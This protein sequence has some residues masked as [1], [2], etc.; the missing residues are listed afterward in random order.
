MTSSRSARAYI[1]SNLIKLFPN[2]IKTEILS[3]SKLS[4]ELGLKTDATITFSDKEVAFSRASLFKAI[5]NAFK[6]SEQEYSVE[7]I[8]NNI[9]TLRNY[10]AESPM[11][12]LTKGSLQLINRNFWP[13]VD[14]KNYRMELFE[15]EAKYRK[16]SKKSLDSWIKILEKSTMSDDEVSDLL[17]DLDCSPT[18]NENLLRQEFQG[19]SDITS[20]LVPSDIRYYERFIGQYRGDKNIEEY[21]KNSLKRHFS[22]RIENKL[23]ENDLLLCIH[24]SISETISIDLIDEAL[25]QSFAQYALNTCHPILL[26][27]CLEIGLSKF[28][29]SSS[30]IIRKLFDNIS[31]E[32]TLEN[33]HIFCS[34]VVF[35]DGELARLQIFRGTPP[36]YRRLASFS[37]SSL[38]LKVVL[39]ENVTFDKIER[40]AAQERGDYFFCQSFI[41]LVEEPRWLPNYLTAEQLLNELYGRLSNACQQANGSEVAEYLQNELKV[42]SRL[43]MRSF[44]PGP[45]E[46]DSSP[47]AMPEEVSKLL[48][49]HIGGEASLESFAV[50]MNSAPLWK[51]DNEY[52]ER[53]VSLLEN[54]QHKLVEV[55]DKD[56]VYQVLNGLAQVSCMTRSRKL[57]SSVTILSRLYRDYI[58]IDS[59]PENYLALGIVAGASYSNKDGWAEFIGQ[60]CTELAFMPINEDAILRIRPMLERLCVLEPYLFHTC[61][62]P[63]DIFKML[64]KE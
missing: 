36:F 23:T 3:D 21:C 57:A 26:I 5:R 10:P 41:D 50:L 47:A 45:L 24:G 58:E 7:D 51:I 59:E 1:A 2:M 60:W 8:N 32:K 28:S 29:D 56:S 62:K 20:T 13:L 40:W 42:S 25:Y 33:L 61:S 53:T 27:S 44:L 19:T 43:D 38:I 64:S 49:K 9:W 34:M 35:V 11:F 17:L 37:Q 22:G 31:S 46:G 6:N 30:E 16:L 52:L 12:S 48:A 54:A 18:H 39:E 14:D 4:E 55:N 63:L 15:S